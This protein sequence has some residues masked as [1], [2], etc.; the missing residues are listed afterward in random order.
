M[1]SS[2]SI[3]RDRPATFVMLFHSHRGFAPPQ[4]GF[5]SVWLKLVASRS[6][7]KT[8]DVLTVCFVFRGNRN[9]PSC[10]RLRLRLTALT[11]RLWTCSIMPQ[12]FTHSSLLENK[13][14]NKGCS[15]HREYPYG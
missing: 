14:A 5:W 6:R 11:R 1:F 7:R 10:A 2:N 3:D 9:V 4:V 13:T 15:Y 12:V 8:E